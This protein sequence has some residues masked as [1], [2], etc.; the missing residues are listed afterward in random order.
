MIVFRKVH[1]VYIL[2]SKIPAVDHISIEYRFFLYN[3]LK[4]LFSGMCL[5]S[6][7][8]LNS[9]GGHENL[10]SYNKNEISSS[11]CTVFEIIDGAQIIL[12]SQ[13]EAIAHDQW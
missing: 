12:K 3:F 7:G 9:K 10:K 6:T 4:T 5:F 11:E 13:N 1:V 2:V 8:P